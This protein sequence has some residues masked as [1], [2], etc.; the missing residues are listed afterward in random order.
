[1]NHII[2]VT[3]IPLTGIN[4]KLDTELF[5]GNYIDTAEEVL[6]TLPIGCG[7]EI[8]FDHISFYSDGNVKNVKHLRCFIKQ[9]SR[10]IFVRTVETVPYI[11]PHRSI[12]FRKKL[13]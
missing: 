9:S 8:M 13:S 12:V 2:S 1:M 4:V 7:I 10:G 3:L 11:S 5:L 6:D